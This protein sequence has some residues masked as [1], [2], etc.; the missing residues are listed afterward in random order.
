M[1]RTTRD[2]MVEW[3]AKFRPEREFET[4]LE[5]V[6]GRSF[7]YAAVKMKMKTETE[8]GWKSKKTNCCA[9]LPSLVVSEYGEARDGITETTSWIL[10]QKTPAV[11]AHFFS[12]LKKWK[13][14]RK[15]GINVDCGDYG[16][17]LKYTVWVSQAEVL[18]S[19]YCTIWGMLKIN[20]WL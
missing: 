18:M 12:M 14:D 4:A 6:G 7:H 10:G 8:P 16:L 13:I 15:Y 11:G 19:Y 20:T 9:V 17:A 3:H 2:G 1:E 5:L